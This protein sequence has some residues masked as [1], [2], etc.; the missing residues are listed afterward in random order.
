M[1][2]M[3]NSINSN[4][5][6]I[7]LLFSLVVMISTVVYALLT[8]ILVNETKKMREV[9]TEPKIQIVLESFEFAVNFLKLNIKNI[10]NGPAVNVQFKSSI[11]NGGITGEKILKDFS[12]VKAFSEGISYLGP[13]QSFNSH[14]TK[15]SSEAENYLNTVLKIET[16]YQSLTR[17]K[18]KE[19]IYIRFNELEGLYQFGK[20]NM[21][22]IAKSLE[23]IEH[24]I[25]W[26]TTGFKKIKVDIYDSD[27]RDEE[28]KEYE[29]RIEEIRESKK[30]EEI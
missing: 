5:G 20:P 3:I 7:S 11:E 1:Q 4:Y 27:D 13:N 14:Y 19:T 24:D 26:I 6:I 8:A 23:K 22:S 12:S 2:E 30:K 16:T 18:Y 9:Q 28:M 21:Y 29:E 25:N 15:Y 17:K 10:G